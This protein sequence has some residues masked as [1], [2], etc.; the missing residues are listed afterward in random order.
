MKVAIT[1]DRAMEFCPKEAQEAIAKLRKSRSKDRRVDP[2]TLPWEFFWG[3]EILAEGIGDLLS[4]KSAE[5]SKR[6]RDMTPEEKLADE[7]A[8]TLVSVCVKDYAGALPRG[9]VP[10]EIMDGIIA[11]HKVFGKI[12]AIADDDRRQA[13]EIVD[14][15]MALKK[16]GGLA[17]FSI[18]MTPPT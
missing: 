4:G 17:V 12:Q 2:K 16:M 6:F 15:I 14:G 18:P 9:T 7:Q 5:R 1:Y 3:T 10:P 13:K 11:R 8:R